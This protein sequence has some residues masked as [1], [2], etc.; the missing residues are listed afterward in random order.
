MSKRS[1]DAVASSQTRGTSVCIATS[2][3]TAKRWPAVLSVLK[4]KHPRGHTL[5]YDSAECLED[6]LIPELRKLLPQYLVIVAHPSEADKKFVRDAHSA[7]CC[8]DPTHP[9]MDVLWGIV[10]GHDEA[11][12]QTMA[13]ED[14]PL[15]IRHV[16][17]GSVQGVDLDAFESGVAFDELV[18]GAGQRKIRGVTSQEVAVDE[19][20]TFQ[21]VQAIED[22]DVDMLI[23]SG[24]ARETEWDIGFLF[25]GGQIRAGPDGILRAVPV[26][27]YEDGKS[28]KI[29]AAGKSKVYSAAG[30]CLM[31]HINADKQYPEAAINCMALSWMHSAGVR[32]MT[33]YTSSTCFGYAGWGVHRYLW[34][35]VGALT[36]AEAFFANQQALRLRLQH[37]EH[38]WQMRMQQ[39]QGCGEPV[40]AQDLALLHE[41]R[42]L[43]H[44]RETTVLYGDPVWEARMLPARASGD[45]Y[46]IELRHVGEGSHRGAQSFEVIVKTLRPGCWTPQVADDKSTLPARPPFLLHHRGFWWADGLTGGSRTALVSAELV[47]TRLFV[48]VPLEGAF[49]AGEVTVR[50]FEAYLH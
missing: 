21:I 9:F 26:C 17:S 40:S 23:T 49:E 42:G 27:L 39:A 35:N 12:A 47:A 7:A 30:N 3:A 45:Y 6:G 13:A 20:A 2:T 43:E 50:R 24:H 46:T 29:N 5:I 38:A 48:M 44:E 16:V 8:I 14:S 10:T 34:A 28:R 41:L 18:Q 15:Q 25:R 37:V 22:P 19:D 36:F 33:G 32:Q 1:V 11:S 4:E 31:A